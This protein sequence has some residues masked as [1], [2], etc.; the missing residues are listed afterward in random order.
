ME[1]IIIDLRKEKLES[2]NWPY[3]YAYKKQFVT[4]D[5]A[6]FKSDYVKKLYLA[7]EPNWY[8]VGRNHKDEGLMLSRDVDCEENVIN[9]ESAEDLFEFLRDSYCDIRFGV[10]RYDIHRPTIY[11]RD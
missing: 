1:I 5:I 2:Y 4:H 11:I 6:K 9:V 10:Y 8:E 7:T 3:A